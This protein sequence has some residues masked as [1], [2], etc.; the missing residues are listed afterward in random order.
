[1]DTS[2]LSDDDLSDEV[3][4]VSEEGG[5]EREERR[6]RR[7]RRRKRRRRRRRRRRRK[8]KRKKRKRRRK[9]EKREGIFLFQP[10]HQSC[11]PSL[12]LIF[13]LPSLSSL[14]VLGTTLMRVGGLPSLPTGLKTPRRSWVQ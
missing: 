2:D 7:R 11:F 12:A 13:L 9:G 8:K 4:G 6:R 5:R 3:D 1:M 14:S 10:H